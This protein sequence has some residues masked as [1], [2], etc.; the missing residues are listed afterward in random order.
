MI[1]S[2]V[3]TTFLDT[4]QRCEKK[5]EY[6]YVK[7]YERRVTG[8]KPERG[9]WVHELLAAHYQ[10]IQDGKDPTK[11]VE[12][13]HSQRLEERWDNLFDEEKEALGDIP[14][15]A[16]AIYERYAE[17][18]R[19]AD[20]RWIRILLVEKYLKIPMPQ[21]PVPLGI[22]CDLVVLD[23]LGFVWV[24][25]HKVVSTIPDEENRMLDTQGPR[26][27]L[28]IQQL[29]KIKG[30]KPK[31]VGMIYD[32]VRDRVPA[33]P[34]LLKNG[35]GLSKA[36]IDTDY[37]TY[38]ATILEHGFDPADYEDKLNDLSLNARPYFERWQVPKSDERLRQELKNIQAIT[39]RSIYP[40]EYYARS[41]DRFSCSW[42]CEYKNL[43]LIELE[44]GDPSLE[45]KANFVVRKEDE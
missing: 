4:A 26:Y 24:V 8:V 32:Y 1:V 10:A 19:E 15:Q 5:L 30:I 37:D 40:K 11:A 22:K 13:A 3:S 27:I 43:C 39:E 12:E 9:T 7:R 36:Q 18:Y 31:G 34:Q 25:D 21:L 6:R 28:G 41:L 14:G 17:R 42:D 44:G 35:K 29:M 16:W 33:K 20:K 38:L 2:S 45:L 23:D